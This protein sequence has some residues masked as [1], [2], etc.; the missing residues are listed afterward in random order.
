[1]STDDLK[2][3]IGAGWDEMSESYQ[4]TTRISLDDVHYGP[5]SPGEREL[6][7]LGDVSGR[8]ALE[9]AC[10]AAQ[11]SIALAKWGADAT[12]V[13]ISARQLS[14]A[15]ELVVQEGV[16][17][18]LLRG[19]MEH[20]SM[21]KNSSFDIVLSSHGWE[22]IPDLA[23]CLGECSRVLQRDGTLVVC[24]VH[25]LAAFEWDADEEGLIVT[26]YF[27]P[28][29]ELW[30]QKPD[31]AQHQGVTFFHTVEEVFGLLTSNGFY[32]E[33]ILEPFPYELHRMSE[34]EKRLIPCAGP[35]W[36]SQYER[37]KRV[38]FTIIYVARKRG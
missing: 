2:R 1:M 4:A 30:T 16:N 19:D 12:A 22:F 23:A 31:G 34:A 26:D 32:V 25:P 10:G 15:R 38:P 6:R 13:D 35:Y 24:T 11:N 8:R 21:L 28:P 5:L 27:N 14:R 7:L 33:R 17:V 20:L 36:D 18:G 9:L 29:V 37:F 3:A